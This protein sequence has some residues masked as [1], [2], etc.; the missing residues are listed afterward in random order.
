MSRNTPLDLRL[1]P[2]PCPVDRVITVIASGR[3]IDPTDLRA[4]EY[5]DATAQWIPVHPVDGTD[6]RLTDTQGV[7]LAI[8]VRIGTR[9]IP[10]EAY[11]LPAGELGTYVQVN[12]ESTA[13]QMVY[14]FDSAL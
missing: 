13:Y 8:E 4:V 1:V 6:L 2:G 9:F 5:S 10:A 14:Q 7:L 3:A 11:V 12:L